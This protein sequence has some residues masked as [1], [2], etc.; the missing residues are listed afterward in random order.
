MDP[1]DS[2][3]GHEGTGREEEQR[4]DLHREGGAEAAER[5]DVDC[6]NG[7]PDEFV[8]GGGW[9]DGWWRGREGAVAAEAPFAVEEEEGAEAEDEAEEERG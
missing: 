1:S 7:V 9:G 4:G 3:V 2:A 8:G 6:F 5:G